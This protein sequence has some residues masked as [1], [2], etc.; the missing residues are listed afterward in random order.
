MCE[1]GTGCA[2]EDDA[3]WEREGYVKVPGAVPQAM[4]ERVKAELFDSIG[5]REDEPESWYAAFASGAKPALFSSPAEWG[6]PLY[7]AQRAAQ[8]R[9]AFRRCTDSTSRSA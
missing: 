2:H 7:P 4:L 6:R 9:S 5:A 3:G 1:C 8:R